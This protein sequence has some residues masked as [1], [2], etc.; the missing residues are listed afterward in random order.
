MWKSETE[1]PY[2]K[3]HFFYSHEF[4]KLLLFRT[5][6]VL[7]SYSEAVYF[8]NTNFDTLKSYLKSVGYES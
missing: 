5:T 8:R 1:L 4:F 7:I 3:N 6:T 2:L